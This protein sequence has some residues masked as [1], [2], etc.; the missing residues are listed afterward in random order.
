MELLLDGQPAVL[1]VTGAGLHTCKSPDKPENSNLGIRI[2]NWAMHNSDGSRRPLPK[3]WQQQI[4]NAASYAACSLDHPLYRLQ[5]KETGI[6]AYGL[7]FLD[8]LGGPQLISVDSSHWTGRIGERI[9][10]HVRDTVRVMQVRIMIWE[11]TES[12]TMLEFGHA[13]QSRL[14]PSIWT[15][16][17]Q[18]EIPQIPGLYIGVL[19]N[20]LAG[21]LGADNVIF[22]YE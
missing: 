5:T 8:C 1:L 15:Y 2:Y 21:N 18:T 14:N 10:F 3:T 17:T 4:L 16:I 22:D 7:A 20:D 19:T 6:N 11:N 13:C 12:K 9:H